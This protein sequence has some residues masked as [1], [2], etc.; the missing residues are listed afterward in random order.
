MPEIAEIA[1]M[2]TKLHARFNGKICQYVRINSKSKIFKKGELFHSP[3]QLTKISKEEIGIEINKP[4]NQIYS[5]G[6]KIIFDLDSNVFISSCG[7]EGHWQWELGKYT[8]LILQFEGPDYAY[9]DDMRRFGN[10]SYVP[11]DSPEYKKIM[12]SVGSD[13]MSSTTTLE[14]FLDSVQ[15]PRN[16]SREICEFLLD[17]KYLSGIGNYLRSEI[18]YDAKINPHRKL[19]SLKTKELDRIFT[20]AK[21]IILECYQ[22]GGLTLATYR[23][24]DG[25][26]GGY[27]P[28][29]YMMDSDSI[30]NLVSKFKDKANRT[31]HWCPKVQK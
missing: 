31:V 12:G 19:S 30:G 15:K 3:V 14:V 21:K 23:D 5:I 18:L 10:F 6:K 1:T 13:W 27:Q 28:Q 29:V 25:N 20:S 4:C 26:A 22:S 8:G 11:K 24:P 2:A 17:Q 9:F 7:M 16:Q